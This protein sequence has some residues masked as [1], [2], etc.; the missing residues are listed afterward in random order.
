MDQTEPK[1][2]KPNVWMIGAAA[3]IILIGGAF[4]L[5]RSTSQTT[6]QTNTQESSPTQSTESPQ[7]QNSSSS[8]VKE[9]TMT[10]KKFEF[11]P[12]TI[13]VSE[14]DKVK[15]TINN[16]DETHGIAITELGVNQILEPGTTTTVEFVASKKG[17][18]R[19][20]CSFFCGSG[21]R[22]ME[23]QIIVQ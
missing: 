7:S 1:T 5:T 11:S 19:Y 10:A 22:E 6:T 16:V 14:G 18:F 17:T 13:T 23:G 3:V 8:S 15:L 21:H 2:N 4:F 12:S 20:F 9:F